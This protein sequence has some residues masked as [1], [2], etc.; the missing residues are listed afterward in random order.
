MVGKKIFKKGVPLFLFHFF[1][2]ENFCV[3]GHPLC[4]IGNGGVC[5]GGNGGRGTGGGVPYINGG[6]G[7]VYKKTALFILRRFLGDFREFIYILIVSPLILI[8]SN[9]PNLNC[10]YLPSFKPAAL[11]IAFLAKVS[12]RLFTCL[13]SPFFNIVLRTIKP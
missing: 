13:Y 10:L 8:S 5:K 4:T 11:T 6:E 7:Y 9:L 1:T 3:K 12:G 2:P